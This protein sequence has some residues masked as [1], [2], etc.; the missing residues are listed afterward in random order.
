MNV[1]GIGENIGANNSSTKAELAVIR[2]YALFYTLKFCVQV[3][4]F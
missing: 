4:R 1:E 2:E 3:F